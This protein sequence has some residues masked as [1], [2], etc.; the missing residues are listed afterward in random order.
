MI[1]RR[2]MEKKNRKLGLN[3]ATNHWPDIL[4]IF[5]SFYAKYQSFI[6]M[7]YLSYRYLC[8]IL[9]FKVEYSEVKMKYFTYL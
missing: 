1:R 7:L 8:R 4:T 9:I 2:A 6:K 5:F 3:V